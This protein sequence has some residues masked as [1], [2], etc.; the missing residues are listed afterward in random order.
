MFN[1]FSTPPATEPAP[2][3]AGR[4]DAVTEAIR[5]ASRRTGVS[6]DYMMRTAQ[7]ESSLDPN[8]RAPTSSATG[9][10][11]FI[12]QTWLSVMRDAGAAF[13]FEREAEVIERGAD[14]R[15]TVADAT[16]RQRIMALRFD[17][18]ANALMAGAYTQRNS[19]ALSQALGRTPSEGELY[20][21]H[22]LGAG[23]ATRFLQAAER[24]PDAPAAAAFPDAAAA[25]R[26]IFHARDGRQ[27]TFAEVRERI[28]SRHA[29]TPVAQTIV[30]A[31]AGADAA[32]V[33]VPRV[34]ANGPVFHSLFAGEGR[35][36]VSPVVQ[37]LWG[38]P[39]QAAAFAPPPRE[40]FFPRSV[41]AV[42]DSAGP[43]AT[44]AAEAPAPTTANVEATATVTTTTIAAPVDPVAQ[45]AVPLPLARPAATAPRAVAATTPMDLMRFVAPR[46]R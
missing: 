6:F 46:S 37:G 41:L 16:E 35:G 40:P 15:L 32:A 11:Q 26:S 29:T 9:L 36:P 31:R 34:T 4:G 8:A 24:T 18:S 38:R 2:R 30:A 5:G 45:R 7:R 14:G 39:T 43:S 19:A 33:P 1:L 27:L 21:A 42:A 20:A 12:D 25:N 3:P 22:F 10:F 28:V 44:R 17:P 13:G 23:G